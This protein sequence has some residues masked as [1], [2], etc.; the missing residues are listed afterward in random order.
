MFTPHQSISGVQYSQDFFSNVPRIDQYFVQCFSHAFEHEHKFVPAKP[1][2]RVTL[3]NAMD[4]AFGDLLEQLISHVMSQ[5][6]V[7]VFEVIQVDEIQSTYLLA[8]RCVRQCLVKAVQQEPTI[9]QSC[10]GVKERQ[11]IGFY[12]GQF[13]G[14]DVCSNP[15]V[16]GKDAVGTEDGRAT[17]GGPTYFARGV[18][19]LH[20]EIVKHLVCVKLLAVKVPFKF[21]HSRQATFP[22]G[23]A[24]IVLPA[25]DRT[26]FV[27]SV[28][29]DEPEFGILFPVPVCRQFGQTAKPLL[30]LPERILALNKMSDVRKCPDQ[31]AC[32]QIACFDFQRFSGKGLTKVTRW[33][34]HQVVFFQLGFGDR[35]GNLQTVDK[36]AP[37]TL[38]PHDVFAGHALRHQASWQIK[39]VQQTLVVNRDA[40]LRIQRQNALAH[41]VE[42][43]LQQIDGLRFFCLGTLGQNQLPNRLAQWLDE[44]QR[45]LGI[46]S[47]PVCEPHH[48]DQ[49]AAELNGNP[50]ERGQRWVPGR[51]PATAWVGRRPVGNHR[52]H[53]CQRCA[54]KRLQVPEFQRLGVTLCKHPA[55]R[56]IPGD[57]AAGAYLQVGLLVCIVKCFSHKPKSALRE[58]QKILQQTIKGNASFCC[59]DESRLRL[60]DRLDEAVLGMCCFLS[61]VPFSHVH[62][63]PCQRNGPSRFITFD[64]ISPAEQPDPVAVS[65]AHPVLALIR[66]SLTL[67]MGLDGALNQR[68]IVRVRVQA[69]SPHVRV[70]FVSVVAEYGRCIAFNPT[71]LDIPVPVDDPGLLGCKCQMLKP[72]VQ[73][74][75]FQESPVC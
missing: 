3:P 23:A 12:F 11:P 21:G 35:V 51:Q 7:Q 33:Q 25:H 59:T 70:T 56:I 4:Q 46:A 10:Q 42:R 19:A 24:N 37:G 58:R 26:G 28:D 61:F 32:W 54:K 27:I 14:G 72:P 31:T 69:P 9:G 55:G 43:G 38:I 64:N 62:E 67:Q 29:S 74:P 1:G 8:P 16:A 36:I 63:H 6:V 53:R 34:A 39:Q 65:M 45:G 41:A 17:D 50:Q 44:L 52:C 73:C 2:H 18:L 49:Q 60:A 30:A 66:E 75:L 22:P 48:A 47:G 13:A 20:L 5:G 15:P 71:T 40:A 57:I 68:Q